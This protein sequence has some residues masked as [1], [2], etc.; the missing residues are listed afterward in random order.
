MGFLDDD[1]YITRYIRV[2]GY[3]RTNSSSKGFP[4]PKF[5][6]LVVNYEGVELIG[7]V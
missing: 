6:F 2:W 7:L 4:V 1:I 5:W 3:K